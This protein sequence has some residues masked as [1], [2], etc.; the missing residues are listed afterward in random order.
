MPAFPTETIQT[1]IKELT[2]G[3]SFTRR[4]QIVEE[5]GHGGMG[6]V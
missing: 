3:S 4:Y 6:K 1:P 2:A 5:L